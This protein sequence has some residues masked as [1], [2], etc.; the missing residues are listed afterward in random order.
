MDIKINVKKLFRG[1]QSAEDNIKEIVNRTSNFRKVLEV[2]RDDI[3]E[4]NY[5][6]FQ[7]QGAWDGRERW[8]DAH[9]YWIELKRKAGLPTTSMIFTKKLMKSLTQEDPN[10][11]A[12]ISDKGLRMG[13]KI[14]YVDDL[15]LNLKEF[16]IR[17]SLL[18]SDKQRDKYKEWIGKYVKGL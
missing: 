17:P 11:I 10:S 7:N 18:F 5:K 12:T 8:P 6:I 1:K 4:T 14:P 9:P 15:Q 3:W 2:I 13:T 16:D